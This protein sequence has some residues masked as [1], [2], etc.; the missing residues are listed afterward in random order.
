[1][2]N[3]AINQNKGLERPKEL[4]MTFLRTAIFMFAILFAG[5]SIWG[6]TVHQWTDEN[7]VVHFSQTAPDK[8]QPTVEQNLRSAPLTG[9]TFAPPK[10]EEKEET[11]ENVAEEQSEPT[12]KKDPAACTRAREMLV[13]IDSGRRLR[14]E[15]PETGEI[16][17]ATEDDKA[18]QREVAN[19]QVER[20][21]N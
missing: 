13:T 7:G 15:D 17:Y 3:G 5:Q 16:T 9:G 8:D 2:H 11:E 12:Y 21:C 10:P 1:M 4:G 20:H 6:V 19:S 18:K 14:F